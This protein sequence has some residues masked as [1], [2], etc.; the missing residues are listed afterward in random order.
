[1]PS[2][3]NQWGAHL[4]L[5][6]LDSSIITIRET[7]QHGEPWDISVRGF[8]KELLQVSG[9]GWVIGGKFQEAKLCCTRD[10]FREQHSII[11]ESYLTQKEGSID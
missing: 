6:N 5:N 3:Q 2:S 9:L 11:L 10:A 8:Q 4:Y 7:A 1:M